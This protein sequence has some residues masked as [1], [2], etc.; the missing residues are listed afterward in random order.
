MKQY[1]TEITINAS[2]EA[3]W[4]ELNN[5]AAY[6]SWNPLVSKLEGDMREG[7]TITAKIV[8]LNQTFK[9]RLVVYKPNEELTWEGKLIASF[10]LTGRHYY[11]LEQVSPTQT[12][13]LHGEKFTGLAAFFIPKSLLLKME[14][15]FIEHN[16]RLKER[17]EN[18]QK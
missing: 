9:A 14:K 13:L 15:V 1:H 17:I 10:L 12:R 4:Q 16:V 6:P 2:A 11:K 7:S 3:V 8:P 18:V 5:F